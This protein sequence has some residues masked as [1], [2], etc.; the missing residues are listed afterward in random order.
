MPDLTHERALI[1]EVG[2]PVAGLDEVGRGPWAGPVVA[3]AVLLPDAADPVGGLDKDVFAALDDSKKLKEAKRDQLSAWLSEHVDYGFGEASVEEIDELNILQ[4]SLLAMR[5]AAGAMKQAPACALVDGN[6]DPRL[7][8]PTRLVVKGDSASIAIAAASVLAKVKR[9]RLMKSL[10]ETFPGYGW[11]S[12]MGYG[13]K[14]HQHGLDHHGVTPHHRKSFAP[15]KARLQI[16]L[17]I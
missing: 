17:N 12:N 16:G 11:D 9:D 15:I 10:A 13:T 14:A 8:I 5:R 2:A 7:G 1:A 6:R 3:C 4:A